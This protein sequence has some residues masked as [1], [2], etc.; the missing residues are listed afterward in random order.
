LAN[1]LVLL[2]IIN[3]PHTKRMIKNLRII[4][5]PINNLKFICK[6]N[7]IQRLYRQLD[8]LDIFCQVIIYAFRFKEQIRGLTGGSIANDSRCPI[9]LIMDNQFYVYLDTVFC[10]NFKLFF[11]ALYQTIIQLATPPAIIA[12]EKRS[13]YEYFNLAII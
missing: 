2:K 1:E 12:K 8:I 10:N 6:N 5:T 3:I 13:S 7:D 9:A 4:F 11:S